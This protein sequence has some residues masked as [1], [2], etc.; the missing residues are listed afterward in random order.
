MTLDPLQIYDWIAKTGFPG[1]LAF[2]IFVSYTG[3]VLYKREF[4][5]MEKSLKDRIS[6]LLVENKELK[7]LLRSSQ[8]MTSSSIDVVSQVKDSSTSRIS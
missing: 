3:R 7:E 1:V 5:Y 4:D 6:E 2:F 8:R